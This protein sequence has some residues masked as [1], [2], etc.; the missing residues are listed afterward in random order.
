MST[1]CGF[2]DKAFKLL[3]PLPV[4]AE[5]PS[6]SLFAK[7]I[8]SLGVVLS[9]EK[10]YPPL[11]NIVFGNDVDLYDA[12]VAGSLNRK[13]NWRLDAPLSSFSGFCNARERKNSTSE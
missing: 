6:L 5:L 4:V 2:S 1:L 11:A 13:D 7:I 9:P 3:P 12:S 8:S 10:E